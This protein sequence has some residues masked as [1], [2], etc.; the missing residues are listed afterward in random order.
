MVEDVKILRRVGLLLKATMGLSLKIVASASTPKIVSVSWDKLPF[1][2]TVRASSS[3]SD[4][5]SF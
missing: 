4:T 1:T 5:M 3:V 2:M